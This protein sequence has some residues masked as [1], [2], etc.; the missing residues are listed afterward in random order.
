M[1][2]AFSVQI[3]DTPDRDE[4]VAEIW[5]GEHQVAEIRTEGGPPRIQIYPAASG[6]W[7][8]SLAE[9]VSVLNKAELDLRGR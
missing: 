4:L 7:D 3:T 1:S 8:F 6:P 5:W 9:L 2:N